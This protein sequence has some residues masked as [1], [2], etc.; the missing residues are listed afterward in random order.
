MPE[1]RMDVAPQCATCDHWDQRFP[2]NVDLGVC[3]R[4]G[5]VQFADTLSLLVTSNP[6]PTSDFK[7]VRTR[8]AFG[9]VMHS[10]FLQMQIVG[11]L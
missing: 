3:Q 8:R 10:D 1:R 7:H 6:T 4:M 5:A 2:Q 11:T 9:C